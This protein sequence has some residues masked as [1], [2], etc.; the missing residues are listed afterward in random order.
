MLLI[1]EFRIKSKE[2]RNDYFM[3]TV[4]VKNEGTEDV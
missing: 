3:G 1:E 4:E 2:I